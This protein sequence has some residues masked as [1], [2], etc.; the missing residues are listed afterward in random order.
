MS[1]SLN[2]VLKD[3]KYS[4][5]K[6]KK[7]YNQVKDLAEYKNVSYSYFRNKN[8][9]FDIFEAAFLNI[10]DDSINETQIKNIFKYLSN[11]LRESDEEDVKLIVMKID[12]L[13]INLVSKYSDFDFTDTPETSENINRILDELKLLKGIIIDNIKNK[14]KYIEKEIEFD[15]V[16]NNLLY[17]EDYEDT[18]VLPL[19]FYN[20]SV[21]SNS[22]NNGKRFNDRFYRAFLSAIH[23]KDSVKKKYYLNLANLVR[24]A[25]IYTLDKKVMNVCGFINYQG[26][27]YKT[28]LSEKISKLEL[29]PEN[30]RYRLDDYIVSIDNENTSKYDDAISI[31]KTGAGTFILGIHIADVYSLGIPTLN[32][33]SIETKSRA[34]LKENIDKNAISLFVEISNTGLIIDKKMLMTNVTVSRN[35]LYDDVS[36]ILTNKA[37]DKLC[38]TVVDLICLYNVV[39]N[40]RLPDFPGPSSMAHS[41][42]QKYMLLY[43][44]I[45]SDMA[46]KNN[47][48]I[49][50]QV[51]SNKTSEVTL[52]QVYC[53]A[54]FGDINLNTYARFT[55]P[56]WDLRSFINQTSIC[57]CIFD[58]IDIK[59]KNELKLTLS[60]LKNK[61]NESNKKDSLQ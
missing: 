15:M 50:Y 28:K 35:L 14:N 53:D 2:S 9:S 43:G 39:G 10:C 4:V 19:L 54:G 5:V 21:L 13:R 31:E 22:K 58:R 24:Q 37:N 20:L 30:G 42:V 27:T 1:E 57:K 48:P 16:C 41:L 8:I 60:C 18:N 29:N 56:I 36:K 44:C 45:V 12:N 52:N 11:N 47:Y 38:Q 26:T 55:S 34:S 49:L 17:P 25:N 61:I 59:E 51:D 3:F 40:T 32:N 6:P 23:E 46:S 33:E 7:F